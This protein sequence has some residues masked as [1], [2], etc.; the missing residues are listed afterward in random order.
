[1]NLNQAKNGILGLLVGDAL[2]VPYE[3]TKPEEIPPFD[4]IEYDPP[5]GF[6]P[7]YNVPP[8]TWSDDGAQALCVL[9]TLL[10]EPPVFMDGVASRLLRWRDEGYMAVDGKVFD[11]GNTTNRA[12]SRYSAGAPPNES[13]ITGEDANSNG[14]LMRTLPVA[15]F[16]RPD[17]ELVRLAMGQSK[18]THAEATPMLCCA[19]YVLWARE[20]AA[21]TPDAWDQA[22]E[23]LDQVLRNVS[24][25][26]LLLA[27]MTNIQMW[28]GPP[29][30]TGGV[31]D[32]LHSA[33]YALDRGTDYESTVKLAIQFGNDTD[34]TAAIAGGLA[35]I[36]YESI[37]ERWLQ[38]L[39]GKEI[40][41]PLLA[42]LRHG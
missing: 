17:D 13:G 32:A 9:D 30:G 37:P 24:R 15:F 1:M 26:G 6:E 2:G 27:F 35:G 18:I 8:G 36:K 7:A 42:K 22:F 14:S 25:N 40:L 21:G 39:R 3:F 41:E 12:L 4:A 33:K 29:R 19:A 31:I 23:S 5:S 34:T 10:E 11:I 20:I 16:E 38:G 28:K